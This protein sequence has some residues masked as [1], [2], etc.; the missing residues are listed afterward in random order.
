[1]STEDDESLV[2]R[3]RE[4]KCSGMCLQEGG[5]S[6]RVEAS[7]K[8]S[9]RERFHSASLKGHFPP[10]NYLQSARNR[11]TSKNEKTN[12]KTGKASQQIKAWS[13]THRYQYVFPGEEG[14]P[15]PAR[16]CP[17]QRPSGTTTLQYDSLETTTLQY[18]SQ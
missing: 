9:V 18:D 7:Q 6:E 2:L 5:K 17:W 3:P 16:M 1:M 15:G 11:K 8:G 12:R 10:S 14:P 4:V 13:R